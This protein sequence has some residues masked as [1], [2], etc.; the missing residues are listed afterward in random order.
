[1]GTPDFAASILKALSSA[2]HEIVLSV[3]QPDR[4]RGRSG[5]LTPSDVAVLSRDLG[6]PVITPAR[7]RRD[8]EAKERIRAA[9][10][11]VIV[12]A[13]FGQILPEE[14]LNIPRYG[15]INVHA[16]LLPRYRGASPI[17][18]A[19]LNGDES[20]G[21]TTMQMDAGLDTGDILEQE[22]IPLDGTETGGELFDKLSE[23]G[24]A[25]IVRTLRD[26]ENGAVHPH[27]QDESRALKVGL[28]TRT[29][30]LINWNRSA[31]EIE[32]MVRAFTPWPSAYT[33]FRGKQ[34]KIWKAFPLDL[35]PEES[36]RTL[37]IDYDLSASAFD[38]AGLSGEKKCL[39]PAGTMYI[40]EKGLFIRC[41]TGY[42]KVL[43]LQS[44]GRK[45]LSADAF[46]RGI[47]F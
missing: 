17:Q 44:E 21:V 38:K 19:I 45:R 34:L 43:E 12:V 30:G 37:T 8:E 35:L 13:A 10:P 42:L 20:T 40:G 22:S 24:A 4:P 39:P 6:I 23:L 11:D 5:A 31:A 47:H 32:R 18:W 33:Y 9:K 29:S 3:T 27:K 26:V 36:F 46:I 2:G 7:I 28:F 25:L 16:S 15:A 14:I 41:G 1:M